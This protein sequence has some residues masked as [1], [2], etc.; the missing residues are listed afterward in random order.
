MLGA[1]RPQDLEQAREIEVS[2]GRGIAREGDPLDEIGGTPWT[3]K[4]RFQLAPDDGARGQPT[5]RP[6][7]LEEERM[8]VL[9]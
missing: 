8:A 1:G 6:G 3:R 9:Q 5:Q 7:D 4:R 2:E